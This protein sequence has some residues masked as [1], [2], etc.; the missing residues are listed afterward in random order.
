MAIAW[1]DSR[2]YNLSAA[3]MGRGWQRIGDL[4][5]SPMVT[6]VDQLPTPGF[7]EWYIFERLPDRMSLTKFGSAIAFLP[8]GESDKADQ[9][10]AQIEGLQP[11]HA[12][13]GACPSLLLITRDTALYERLLNIGRTQCNDEKEVS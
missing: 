6:D 7:D 8:F 9:F 4:A 1:L 3:E 2:R 5:I 12:L 10:W 11:T 13:L